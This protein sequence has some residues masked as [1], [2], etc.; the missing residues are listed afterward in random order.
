MQGISTTAISDTLLLFFSL[1]IS[2][3]KEFA[4]SD[5][6]EWC[7]CVNAMCTLLHG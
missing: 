6:C 3:V 7:H 1:H 4:Y 2:L 5:S